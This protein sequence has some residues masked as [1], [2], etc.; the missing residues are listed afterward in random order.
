M[1]EAKDL[2]VGWGIPESSVNSF[3]CR[4]LDIQF[5]NGWKDP[6]EDFRIVV[7]SMALNR[8]EFELIAFTYLLY[9]FRSKTWVLKLPYASSIK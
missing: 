8:S 2:L 4:W 3:S 9:N 6:A 7:S 1:I 5:S